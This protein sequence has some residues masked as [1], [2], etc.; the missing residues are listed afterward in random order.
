MTVL[1]IDAALGSFSAAIVGGGDERTIE[2][3]G[4][5]ALE[6]GISAIDDLLREDGGDLARIAV[7]VGPGGF[8]GL[9]IALS[10]AKAL[11][12]AWSLPLVGVSS[13]DAIEAGLD[14]GRVLTIV[15]GRTGVISARYRDA[16]TMRR[17]SGFIADVLAAVLPPIVGALDVAGDAEDVLRAL[18]ERGIDVNTIDSPFRPAALAIAMLGRTREP[19]DNAHA[20]RADYGE[21]PAAKVP[22][23]R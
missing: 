18:D 19:A 22:S 17:A 2:L 1:G 9:R 16:H 7:G 3:P 20:V 8:T 6:G 12:L 21:L 10:Y 5:R 4:N 11:S 23:A 13:F 14:L 15:K